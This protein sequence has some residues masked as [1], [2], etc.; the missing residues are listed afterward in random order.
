LNGRNERISFLVSAAVLL[1]SS[2]SIASAFEPASDLPGASDLHVLTRP[3]NSFLIAARHID[4]DEY[5]IP[6]GP[7]ESNSKQ[8]GKSTTATAP[9]D[10][11]TW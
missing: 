10:V 8:P 1:A 7:V 4:N 3:A 9:I 5:A 2:A 11:L 6:L